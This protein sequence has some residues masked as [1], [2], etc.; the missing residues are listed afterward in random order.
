MF[1]KS[2]TY[3]R[4]HVRNV[5]NPKDKL[6]PSANIDSISALTITLTIVI[7]VHFV[8]VRLLVITWNDIKLPGGPTSERMWNYSEINIMLL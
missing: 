1:N 6:Y 8:Y 4:L 3:S 2:Y 5:P 7:G